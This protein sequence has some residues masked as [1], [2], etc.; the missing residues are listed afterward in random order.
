MAMTYSKIEVN[1]AI[2]DARF[3]MPAAEKKEAAP[4]KQ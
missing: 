3:A 4:P 2:E 1:P